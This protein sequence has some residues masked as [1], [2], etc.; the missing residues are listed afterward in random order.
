MTLLDHKSELYQALAALL[1]SPAEAEHLSSSYGKMGI[2][3]LYSW[4]KDC[5]YSSR[6]S[7]GNNLVYC[8]PT[9]GGKTLVAELIM[10][11]SVIALRKKAI[12][13]VPYVSLYV[14]L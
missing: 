13:V 7:E 11:R 8:A 1:Q 12:L 10:F 6:L 5:I 4:Q 14:R 2:T 9:G 3:S